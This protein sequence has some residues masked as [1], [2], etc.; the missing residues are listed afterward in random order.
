MMKRIVVLGPGKSELLAAME[1]LR[2]KH[3]DV[4]AAKHDTCRIF[5]RDLE[6][7]KEPYAIAERQQTYD[8][9]GRSRHKKGKR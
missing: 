9:P 4:M 7:P 6:T 1:K 3:A 2:L 8:A 5:S